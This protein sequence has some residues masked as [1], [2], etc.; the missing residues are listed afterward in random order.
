MIDIAPLALPATDAD[1]RALAE[2]LVDAVDA[3]GIV[4]SVQLHSA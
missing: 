1:V 4:E 3:G 2:L